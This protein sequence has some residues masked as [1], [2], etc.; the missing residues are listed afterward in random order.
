MKNRLKNMSSYSKKSATAYSI[1]IIAFIIVSVLDSF[2]FIT[3]SLYGQ[4]VPICAYIS[5][6]VS[7]NL[8][9]FCAISSI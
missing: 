9:L 2:G 8:V 3:N 6:A 4:L 1:V 7:L 5:L